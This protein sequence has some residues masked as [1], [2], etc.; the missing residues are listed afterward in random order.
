MKKRIALVALMLAAF[1]AFAWS[2]DAGTSTLDDATIASLDTPKDKYGIPTGLY[3]FDVELT[4]YRTVVKAGEGNATLIGVLG[5]ICIGGGGAP[6][7]PAPD[8]VWAPYGAATNIPYGDFAVGVGVVVVGYDLFSV[9]PGID[10]NKKAM[11]TL[12]A[13]RYGA[14]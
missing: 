12:Y 5:G 9:V 2:Q 7:L 4:N 6:A 11:A 3:A 1:G 10:K 8:L 14:Y 13:E